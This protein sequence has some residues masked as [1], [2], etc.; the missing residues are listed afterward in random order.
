M[1]SR[2]GV[3][4]ICVDTGGTFT[5]CIAIDPRG[6]SVRTK[7]LSSGSLRARA[8]ASSER[9]WVR[10]EQ[11]WSARPEALAGWTVRSLDS[12]AR[13]IVRAFDA[14]NSRVE[15]E[16]PL[17]VTRGEMLE[18]GTGEEAPVVAA[19]L[20]TGAPAG[21]PLPPFRM[22]LATTRGTNALLERR[23]APT[24]LF[25]TQGFGDLLEIGDQQRPELFTLR[26]KKRPPLHAAVVEVDERLAADGTVLREPDLGRLREDGARVLNG[27]V[28]SAA[29]ALLHSWRN[30]AHEAAVAA[31]LRELG[32]E[33][34][35]CSS[36]LSPLIKIVPRAE[37]AVVNA[38]LSPVIDRY[39]GG[40]AGAAPGSR[41][42]VMTSS[43]GLV[44]APAFRPKDALLSGPAG[45]VIGAAAAARRSGFDRVITFDM[46]GTS[47]DVARYDARPEYTF[48][49]AVGEAQIM[50]PAVAVESV[51]AGGGSVCGLG[52]EGQVVG[53]RSAGALPGPACYG[54]GGPLTVTDVNLLLGRVDPR[55]FGIPVDRAAAERRLAELLDAI[56]QRD[57]A[58][59]SGEE[60]LEG[61]AEIADERMAD[62]IRS[63][64]VR[65]GYDP[66]DYALVAF[67]G[68]GGQHAC[69]IADRLGIGTVIVPAD[70]GLLSAAGLRAAAVERI[71]ERQLL[72]P[73]GEVQESIPRTMAELAAEA[74]AALR[75][76]TGGAAVTR[77]RA[78]VSL[79]YRGLELSVPIDW[80]EGIDLA[81][82]FEHRYREVY[83][84]V[85]S[86]RP[87]EIESVRIVATAD[88]AADEDPS[89]LSPTLQSGAPARA[90]LD[91]WF[92]GR[93][94]AAELCD[95]RDLPPGAT[96]DGPAVITDRYGTT[97]VRP[98][99]RA[100]VDPAGA[101]VLRAQ[102]RDARPT[103]VPAAVRT[104]LFTNRLRKIAREMGEMLRRTSLST[105]IKERLDFSCGIL[106]PGGELVVNAPHIPVHLGA[107]GVCV[108][109]LLRTIPMNPGDV[110]VTNHPAAGGSHL[111]DVTVVTPVY[112]KGAELIGYVA[113]RA[114]HAEIGGKTPGSMPPTARSLAEEGVVI[115]PMSL[116]AG[117]VPDWDGLRRVLLGG[118]YPTRAVE[119][120]LAD[121]AAAVAANRHGAAAL[122]DMT[123]HEGPAS[124]AEAMRAL[125]DGAERSAVAALRERGDGVA[126]AEERLDDG[127]LLR[128]RIE[129]AGGRA[130]VDFAGSGGI[131]PGNLN[132]TPAIVR[133]AVMYV[134]RLLIGEPIPLNEGLMRA[135]SVRLPP[136]ILNPPFM[137]DPADC[138]AVA[139]GNTET[140][141][142]VVDLLIKA[143]GLA[144]CSQGTMNSVLFGNDR[145]GY[146][147]T[148]CG[149]EGACE[150]H[151]GASAVHTHMTNTRITDP[152]LLE[153]R[154]PVRV[155]RFQIRRGSGGL[156]RWRGGDGV[157]REIRFLEPMTLSVVGEHRRAG[158]F[159]LRGGLPGFPADHRIVRSDGRVV[160]IASIDGTQ[161]EPGDRFVLETPGGGGFAPPA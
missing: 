69:G 53:P 158:P 118:P 71:V 86:G 45:G 151:H 27:G 17:P 152:E 12:G 92:A 47:T 159:G 35:S 43:G 112:T 72:R 39:L 81:S 68:A 135:V 143:L 7:V 160:R 129:I 146:Y 130:V 131:H 63:V 46:G 3:W 101:I 88:D 13:S 23:G 30:P 100:T 40:V 83:S 155:E 78:I 157:V 127:T 20:V 110:I 103:V 14:E 62:A 119:D 28:R 22:R 15:L 122:R 80:T 126:E 156:G 117:G 116:F 150:G 9:G 74:A 55:R 113:S 148:V 87:I 37:T 18:F 34:V 79:R 96:L 52:P 41:L 66:A 149:G 132:A 111:P 125:A 93:R 153:H 89:P 115:A 145:F 109:E 61:F 90:H 44:S 54:A 105:N 141:Q 97:T 31:V 140:S 161:V 137:Q 64:S 60:V 94:V 26:I 139:A 104:E 84:H 51:A 136:G 76:D 144:A 19:R 107:L 33:H 106:D 56:E 36:E 58:R 154:Y 24:A 95:R 38:F 147:E 70:A 32:F 102:A 120:N 138:P 21:V 10:V 91:A 8:V 99:W 49:H 82:E 59:P 50:A 142:R 73:L 128:V 123:A 134:F 29:V 5:D 108:R 75:G 16:E 98:G 6:R 67:G 114:H 25:V 48:E 121:V 65:R 4:Q 77:T 1:D 57:G 42:L 11:R 2:D 133:S 124:V 85:P